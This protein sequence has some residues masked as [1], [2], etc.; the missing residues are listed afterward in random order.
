[1]VRPAEGAGVDVAARRAVAAAAG[2]RIWRFSPRPTAACRRW[3]RWRTWS[4]IWS[5]PCVTERT[6]CEAAHT[7]TCDFVLDERDWTG[8]EQRHRER[9]DGF[10]RSF[11]APASEPHPVWDFLFTYYSLRPRQLRTW[12]PGFGVALAG[13]SAARY[14]VRSGYGRTPPV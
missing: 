10:L 6:V 2:Q 13:D 7:V 8:R 14:L 3:W 12:H 1:M 5:A 11:R 4:K 9:V